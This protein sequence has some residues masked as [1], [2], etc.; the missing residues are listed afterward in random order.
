MKVTRGFKTQNLSVAQDIYKKWEEGLRTPEWVG[1]SKE[2]FLISICL[3]RPSNILEKKQQSLR[4]SL[5]TS[6]VI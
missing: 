6:T 4:G 2:V 5:Y 1:H 3:S